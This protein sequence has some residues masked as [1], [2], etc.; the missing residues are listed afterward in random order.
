MNIEE[1]IKKRKTEDRINEFDLEN[2]VENLRVVV[3][4]VF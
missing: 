3:N 1:Y 2:R 4:Y